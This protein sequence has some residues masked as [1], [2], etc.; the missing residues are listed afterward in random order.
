MST[1]PSGIPLRE[2][3]RRLDT[4]VDA[5]RKRI[6]RGSVQAFKDEAGHWY[7][8]LDSNQDATS[9][10]STSGPPGQSASQPDAASRTTVDTD[11]LV[12]LQLE[13]DR[14]W[15]QIK[16]KDETISALVEQLKVANER[17]PALP[18]GEPVDAPGG[19]QTTAGA[20]QDSGV[21]QAGSAAA[22]G[23]RAWLRARLRP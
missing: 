2:A 5:I 14:L 21:D 1:D 20:S 10:T 16:V 6:K 17:I 19:P 3:A 23:F 22:V 9:H 8:I 12:T 7:V 11:L 15:D 18:A 4:S 13:I